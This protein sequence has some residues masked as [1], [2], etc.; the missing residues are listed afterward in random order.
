MSIHYNPFMWMARILGL[1]Y[2]ANYVKQLP[3]FWMNSVRG[4]F[5]A[6]AERAFVEPNT[7]LAESVHPRAGKH[8]A[9]PA[10]GFLGFFIALP[11]R[12]ACSRVSLDT[13]ASCPNETRF[14]L[15]V[16]FVAPFQ[17]VVILHR[18]PVRQS[19][20]PP[21]TVTR[22]VPIG[23]PQCERYSSPPSML[24][25]SSLVHAMIGFCCGRSSTLS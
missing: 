6:V 16:G 15:T 22:A 10:P 21:L 19:S 9:R 7:I 3:P 12:S 23:S 4:N 13:Q 18:P 17:S 8:K 2:L 20:V 14:G 24:V 1:R 11:N 25:L 5:H